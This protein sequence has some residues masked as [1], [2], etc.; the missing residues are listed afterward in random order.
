MTLAALM[1]AARTLAP[2]ASALVTAS[3][4]GGRTVTGIA[5]DSRAV[6]P[7]AVFV[8]VR[9]HRV[10]GTTF[11]ADA[12][13]RGAM[14]VVAEGPA[15]AGVT[16]PWLQ[17][18][19]AR[20]AL[21]ELAAIFNGRPSERLTVVGVTG[22]NGKTTITYL[23]ASVLD[24]AGLPCGRLGTVT[25]RVGPDRRF[26]RDAAHTTPEA[27]DLQALLR[28]M[29]DQGCQ[30]CAMEVSSH[31]LVLHRVA[32][33]RFAAAIFTNLTRDHLDFHVDMA[34]YFAAK[35]RLFEMLPVGAPA[36]V[37]I[38]DPRGA[39]LA[40]SLSRVVTYGLDR[41]ADVRGRGIQSSLEGLAFEADTPRGPL[42]IRSPLVGR[43]NAYNI[44]SV[45]ALGVAL[46]LPSAAIERGIA[47]LESV[48]GRFQMV[49]GQADDVRV[50]VDY[51][52]T[53]DALK[54]L[55]ETARPLA[56]SRLIVVFGC[57]G[58]RDKTK[59]PL[60]GAVAGRLADVV[61]LTSDN[62]RSENPDR[63]IDEIKRGLLPTP[64]P[65]APPR[66]TPEWVADP[67][68]RKAIDLAVRQAAP[69]DLVVI[70]GKGHE[71]YQ[72][73]GDRTLPFDD[74]EVARAA[75]GQRRAA[76]RV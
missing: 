61:V 23:L 5:H 48:P 35:R 44:L 7:G 24:A 4:E 32:E 27:S 65:G 73:I 53:D 10:D 62:P 71:K 51:A 39:E 63:I 57:G 21:A 29:V 9:G 25:F 1:T 33:M 47:A 37:N 70:A 14:A 46:D 69:G 20:L 50:V 2:G 58:D 40:A 22:T 54:N 66:A 75:L 16:V 3:A 52:H 34:A 38:D 19:N 43:P 45:V 30:A 6:T 36:I 76:P 17:T 59:R 15:P 64:E 68:R 67:D 31:A 41:P 60:M 49:S 28:E 56:G 26:E 13:A 72:V 55:L 18:T 8:A 11:A 42:A 12:V 74:V